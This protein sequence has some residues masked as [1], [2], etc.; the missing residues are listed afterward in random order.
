MRPHLIP[1]CPD[2]LGFKHWKFHCSKIGQLEPDGTSIRLQYG[3]PP[4]NDH[5]L[6]RRGGKKGE[7][8]GVWGG[9]ILP[10]WR[11][12]RRWCPSDDQD[13]ERRAIYRLDIMKS[14]GKA[15]G[16]R[17]SVFCFLF[18]LPAEFRD[19][20]SWIGGRVTTLITLRLGHRAWD[21]ALELELELES[22]P[23]LLMGGGFMGD[24]ERGGGGKET[25]LRMRVREKLTIGLG[26]E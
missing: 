5:P 3:P 1:G 17:I 11:R 13:P 24:R 10:E 4:R 25:R 19:L 6:G 20:Y 23:V 22:P 8:G 12:R 14:R 2:N 15:R 7:T 9:A 16:R 21:M 18:Y 26:R